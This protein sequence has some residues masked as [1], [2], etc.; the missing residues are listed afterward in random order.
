MRPFRLVRNNISQLDIFVKLFFVF[1]S[2][3]ENSFNKVANSFLSKQ[4]KKLLAYYSSNSMIFQIVELASYL[5]LQ[6]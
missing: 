3:Y 4:F 2:F 6:K 1:F 5:I